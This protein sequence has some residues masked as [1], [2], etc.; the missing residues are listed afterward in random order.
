VGTAAPINF[1]G[2]VRHY[3]LR[4]GGKVADIQVNF[5]SKDERK[6]QSHEIAKRIRPA[7]KARHRYGAR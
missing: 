3:F 7:I 5:V 2:L 1:N 6:T 4:S